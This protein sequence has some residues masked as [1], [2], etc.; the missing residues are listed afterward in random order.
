MKTIA[1]ASSSERPRR[2]NGTVVTSAALFS[3]VPVKRVNMPV[4]VG[5]GATTF[6]RIPALAISSATD[7][8]RPSTACLLTG[9]ENEAASI[10]RR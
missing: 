6:T 4:S 5:R 3:G 1:L 8:V 7:L 9:L 10:F 2:P